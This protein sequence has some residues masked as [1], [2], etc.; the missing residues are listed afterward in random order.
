MVVA[1]AATAVAMVS[2]AVV[3]DAGRPLQMLVCQHPVCPGLLVGLLVF[4]SCFVFVFFVSCVVF[5]PD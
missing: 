1:D 3:S 2:E 5:F 4:V